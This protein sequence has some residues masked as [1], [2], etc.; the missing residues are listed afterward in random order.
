[1][2]II[3]TL[4][5]ALSNLEA[6]VGQSLLAEA[7]ANAWFQRQS[8]STKSHLRALILREQNAKPID[9]PMMAHQL[10]I[11]FQVMIDL[12]SNKD[13]G[14]L[15]E[16]PAGPVKRF[17]AALSVAAQ[18]YLVTKHRLY[19][20][21]LAPAEELRLFF[22]ELKHPPYKRRLFGFSS[23]HIELWKKVDRKNQTRARVGR[24]RGK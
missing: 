3:R 5:N 15:S 18:E 11:A 1:M 8:D 12:T 13:L 16:A 21:R 17:R 10:P 19:V 14:W 9:L 6:Y 20:A 22:F 23:D 24:F 4:D 2:M 7:N